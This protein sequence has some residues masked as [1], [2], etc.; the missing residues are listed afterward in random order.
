[1]K[2]Y[3]ILFLL[4][5]TVS[6]STLKSTVHTIGNLVG[7]EEMKKAKSDLS[8]SQQYYFGRTL[9]ASFFSMHPLVKNQE[10][11]TYMRNVGTQLV[12][13]IPELDA[14]QIHTP[15]KG[16]V[17][18]LVKADEP[19][20]F[21]TPGGFVIVSTG[22]IKNLESEDQ[23]AGILSHEM[24]HILWEHALR[25]IEGEV[26]KNSLMKIGGAVAKAANTE[27]KNK[28][29]EDAKT[30][31]QIDEFVEFANVGF[32]SVISNPHS[33]KYEI[34]ADKWAGELLV[35]SQYSPFEFAKLIETTKGARFASK[36]PP[37]KKRAE[38]FRSYRLGQ[39]KAFST[40]ER[41][42][43]FDRFKKHLISL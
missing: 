19:I 26:T 32:T 17:F 30:N 42:S 43:R 35:A 10:A 31:E 7:D 18:A 5:I 16:F 14:E 4:L 3:F 29:V 27:I 11:L 6:C 23:L 22:L 12:L 21:S 37:S 39:G 36:H 20:A 1:M 2:K 34:E 15:Y 40:A 24:G 25:E 9:L 33:Q 38:K 28:G 41:K 13:H 8:P